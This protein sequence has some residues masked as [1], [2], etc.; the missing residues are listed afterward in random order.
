MEIPQRTT[1]CRRAIGH[2]AVGL[3]VRASLMN[4]HLPKL[5]LFIDADN[6]CLQAVPR[7]LGRLSWN[8]DVC[9]RRAYGM[10]LRNEGEILRE[11]SIV[12]VEVLNNTPHK[13]ST[14]FALVID[15]M[16]ELCLGHSEAICIVSGDGDFTRLVQRIRETGVRAIV[17]G[18]ASSAAALRGACS[19]FHAIEDLQAAQKPQAAQ[20]AQQE[21]EASKKPAPPVPKKPRAEQPQAETEAAVRNGLQQRFRQLNAEGKTVTLEY[22]GQFL[23]KSHPKLA[24]PKFGLSRLKPYLERIGG[25]KIQPVANIAGSNRVTLP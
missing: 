21:I 23:K 12:P 4:G 2:P 7:I 20:N 10:N 9:Y 6:I 16:E 3:R 13:N 1:G 11:H 5:A 14:D 19:E 8:W 15:A 24:P 22:F 25:F 18:K 17:F